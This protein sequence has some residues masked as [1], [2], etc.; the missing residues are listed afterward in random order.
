MKSFLRTTALAAVLSL[1][2]AATAA[3]TAVSDISVEADLSSIQNATAA[4]V[5]A[6]LPADL[7]NTLAVRLANQI[8][9]EG[10]D[11]ADVMIDITSVELASSFENAANLA[12]SRITGDVIIERAGSEYDEAYTL[13]VSAEQ[14]AVL[15]PAGAD[16]MLLTP[17]SMEFYTAMVD[18]FAGNIVEKLQ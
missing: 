13:T 2:L 7:Q 3:E 9:P 18:A 11:G 15:L 1:P 5:W 12:D 16:I 14:A 4:S 17:G 10:E 6:N 8:A